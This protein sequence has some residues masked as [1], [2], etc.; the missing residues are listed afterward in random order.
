IAASYLKIAEHDHAEATIR[1]MQELAAE[2][3]GDPGW[4]TRG[5]GADAYVIA[6]IG[7]DRLRKPSEAERCWSAALAQLELL[8]QPMFDRRLARVRATLARRWARSK[9]GEARRLASAA[10]AWYRGV[11]GYETAIGELT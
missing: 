1:A 6:A 5:E 11:G 9:P 4:W 10:V 3:A 2:L 8:K 7:W